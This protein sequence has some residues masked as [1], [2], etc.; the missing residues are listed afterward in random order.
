MFASPSR[1]RPSPSMRLRVSFWSHV[2]SSS[3]ALTGAEPKTAV[4]PKTSAP[5]AQLL[6]TLLRRTMLIRNRTFKPLNFPDSC[7]GSGRFC[8]AVHYKRVIQQADNPGNDGHVGH[9]KYIPIEPPIG[10]GNV[11]KHEISDPTIGQAV[12]G[13]ADRAADDQAKG[14]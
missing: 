7:G 4:A 5:A 9:V 10:R 11:E 14:Q 1:L 8:G 13:I 12:D 3:A 2:S 6:K